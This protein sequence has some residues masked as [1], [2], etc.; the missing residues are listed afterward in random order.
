MLITATSLTLADHKL[1]QADLEPKFIGEKKTIISGVE[2]KWGQFKLY[3][4]YEQG[5]QWDYYTYT[6][7]CNGELGHPFIVFDR[8]GPEG[9][10]VFVY[11][12]SGKEIDRMHGEDTLHL[13]SISQY[14][15]AKYDC[16]E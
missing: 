2:I 12:H 13:P 10:N 3:Q 9:G 15:Q 7:Y 8:L 4:R 14:Q 11:D 16:P 5:M 6:P 1:I